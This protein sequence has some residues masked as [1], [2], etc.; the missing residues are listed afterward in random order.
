MASEASFCYLLESYDQ[1]VQQHV[2]CTREVHS[3]IH[4]KLP[5]TPV[6]AH[7]VRTLRPALFKTRLNAVL[8]PPARYPDALCVCI[9]LSDALLD[10]CYILDHVI[11]VHFPPP[12][13]VGLNMWC[14]VQIM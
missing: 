8:P 4:R 2:L 11:I 7:P 5:L 3:N 12:P 10:A 13:I 6:I 1:V 14:G 9:C